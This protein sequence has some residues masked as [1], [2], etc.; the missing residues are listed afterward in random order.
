MIT[1][2]QNAILNLIVEMFTRT[3]E[4]VGSKALQESIDS[5]SATI[6]NDMAK[7]EKMGYLEKAHT[8]SGRMPSRAGFQ[9]FV[10]NSLNLDTID[11][12]DIY[13]VVKAFDFEAFKLED[14]LDAAAKLLAEMTGCTAVI[15][16]VEPTRQRLTGFDIVHL[17]NHDALAVLTLDESKPVTVQFAI[18]KNFL[19]SDLETLHK[20]VQERF[21]GNTVLDIHYRLRTEIPQIV[22]KYF[23]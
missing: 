10:A 2:R 14:I 5:S 12:Q 15:Q 4:P 20:L 6:R 16:D 1:Q 11:E 7:L 9:Y 18:P 3:H 13:Q 8:S 22:Q 17:S 23:K 21:L 19:S